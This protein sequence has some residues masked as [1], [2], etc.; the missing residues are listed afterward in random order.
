V[1]QV[2]AFAPASVGNV[3]S[4]STSSAVR[5]GD[6]RPRDLAQE[7]DAGVRIE[8]I[9]AL[10]KA[11]AGGG[12]QHGWSRTAGDAEELGLEF[13]FEVTIEK[14]IPLGSGLGGSA[15]SAV[16]AVVA[17]NDCCQRS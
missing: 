7:R 12:T 11:S 6:R 14:G 10:P 17:A 15:A 2:T 1:D 16:G 8:R 4:A 9:T 5:R 3:G 13:G